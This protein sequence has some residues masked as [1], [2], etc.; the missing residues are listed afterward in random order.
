MMVFEAKD[1]ISTIIPAHGHTIVWADKKNGTSQLH[2]NFKLTN[3]DSCLVVITAADESWADTL[4]YHTHTE[5]QTIGLYPD[6]GSN[7]Y[8]FDLPTLNRTNILSYY[9]QLYEEFVIK[10]SGP[11]GIEELNED[12]FDDND[13]VYDLSGRKICS[14]SHFGTLPRGIYIVNGRKVLR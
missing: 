9:A 11:V 8:T 1:G 14:K 4:V 6:G 13:A 2:A 3:K 12:Y 5:Q 7:L 10:P